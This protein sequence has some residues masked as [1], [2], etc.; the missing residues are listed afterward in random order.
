MPEA[1][2]GAL[3]END[4]LEKAL[5]T[6]IENLEKKIAS[7]EKE[8]CE[9]QQALTQA[10]ENVETFVKTTLDRVGNTMHAINGG[11]ELLKND[12]LALKESLSKSSPALADRHKTILLNHIEEINGHVHTVE[13]STTQQSQNTANMLQQFTQQRKS[14][15]AFPA[16]NMFRHSI[17]QTTSRMPITLTP[18]SENTPKKVLIVD[19]DTLN[20]KL[21]ERKLQ[22][23][24]HLYDTASNGEEALEKWQNA[25][26]NGA[27]F[28]VIIMDVR[29]P[30][31]DGLA[32]TRAIRKHELQE[33]LKAIFIIGLSANSQEADI[34]DGIDS[35]MNVYLAKPC[36][37]E[38]LRAMIESAPLAL[39]SKASS[40][41]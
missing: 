18:T 20:K 12:L 22:Q 1:L 4:A 13:T 41:P 3:F 24:K 36:P 38:T 10:T 34:Q 15:D 8:N 29:M 5:Q 26:T 14:A 17:I 23:C 28:D 27:P 25:I 39:R 2:P 33:N 16:T 30:G 11:T 31:M 35:G 32:A 19:D 7:L 21:L 6:K 9:L 37:L 40:S